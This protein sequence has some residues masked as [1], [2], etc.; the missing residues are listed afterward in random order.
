VRG[1][2]VRCSRMSESALVVNSTSIN[3]PGQPLVI[4]SDG[5]IDE[6]DLSCISLWK[7]VVCSS[8]SLRREGRGR[9]EHPV[10]SGR[11]FSILRSGD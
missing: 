5:P 6:T 4:A 11:R 10:F 9:Y 8:V 2:S 1:W 7:V 3:F